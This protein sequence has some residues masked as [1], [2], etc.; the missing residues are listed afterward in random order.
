MSIEQRDL[1]EH[2]T[3]EER[4]LDRL[5][6]GHLEPLNPSA[7]EAYDRA[8]WIAIGWEFAGAAAFLCFVGWLVSL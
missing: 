8:E 7:R 5:W 2:I 3:D 1:L 6:Y 4:A